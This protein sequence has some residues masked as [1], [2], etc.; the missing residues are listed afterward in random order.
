MKTAI[1]I[2]TLL[3]LALASTTATA[4]DK[5]TL[6]EPTVKDEFD[7]KELGDKWKALKG[8]WKIED[9]TIVGK[10]LK[11]DEHAAVLAFQHRNHNSAIE[12]SFKLDGIKGFNLSYNKKKGHLFRV[13]VAE[14]RLSIRL[15][16]DKKDPTSR[17]K[18]LATTKATFNKGE[19][20]TMRVTLQGDKVVVT[21]SNGARLEATHPDLDQVK[22][23]Y[24]FVMRGGNLVLDNLKVW[25]LK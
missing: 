2:L 10:E 5:P 17:P 14:Q 24:R 12:F 19:W 15:D 9:G 1:A 8:E 13:V 25:D 4:K 11:T 18:Q 22:P 21:T 20:C 23:N 6:G 7:R 3:T 16:K